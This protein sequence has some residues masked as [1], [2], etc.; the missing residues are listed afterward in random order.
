VSAEKNG[1]GGSKAK[2]FH[3]RKKKTGKYLAQVPNDGLVQRVQ[4]IFT[5]HAEE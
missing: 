1:L 3:F 5:N 4:T 2:K